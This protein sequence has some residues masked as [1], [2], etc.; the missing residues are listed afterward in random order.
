MNDAAV[1]PAGRAERWIRMSLALV[2]G[3]AFACLAAGV[4]WWL[5]APG[6]VVGGHLLTAGLTG[7]LSIPMLRLA[8]IVLSAVRLRDWV[9][10]GATLAVI[11]ILVALTLRDAARA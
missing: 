6:G 3:A 8:A 7:L 10:L 4:V 2:F 9:L 1:R 11:A 5:A